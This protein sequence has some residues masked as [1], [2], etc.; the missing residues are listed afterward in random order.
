MAKNG[1]IRIN[2]NRN[3]SL[4]LLLLVLSFYSHNS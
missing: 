4:K 2:D 1:W 3:W